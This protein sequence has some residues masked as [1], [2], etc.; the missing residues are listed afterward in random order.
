[1]VTLPEEEQPPVIISPDGKLQIISHHPLKD[2]FGCYCIE[3]VL[4][5]VSPEPGLYA[6][7]KIDYH[8]RDGKLIDT[9]VNTVN[10]AEP[11]GTRSFY[12]MYSGLRRGEIEYYK[13]CVM[14]KKE[15]KSGNQ[16]DSG[17]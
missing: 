16:A 5:Y 11:G 4:K 17:I 1:M 15:S 9:E 2:R 8:D 6:E 10:F 3:G 13:L 7:I 12:I 14:A